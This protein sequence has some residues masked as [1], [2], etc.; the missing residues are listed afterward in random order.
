MPGITAAVDPVTTV[1]A[2]ASGIF[3]CTGR[4]ATTTATSSGSND[5]RVGSIDKRGTPA[6]TRSVVQINEG[7]VLPGEPAAGTAGAWLGRRSR[8][9]QHDLE[10][11]ADGNWQ[12]HVDHTAVTPGSALAADADQGTG[13]SSVGSV[14]ADRSD[15]DG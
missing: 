5:R 8:T 2:N 15:V 4:T 9:A 14:P 7:G 12:I 1:S 6:V 13:E 11:L 10:I 3:A